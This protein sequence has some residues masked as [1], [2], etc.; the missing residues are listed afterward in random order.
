[1]NLAVW[2]AWGGMATGVGVYGWVWHRAGEQRR[3]WLEWG[4]ALGV[5]AVSLVSSATHEPWRDELHAWLQA[6]EMG[7]GALWEEMARE[8]HFLPWHL[9]LWPLAH[10]GVPVWTMG[11]VSWALNAAAVWW[12]ARRSPLTGWEKAAVG[13]SCVFLYVNPVISRCYALAP[14]ALSGMAAL[15]KKRDEWPMVFGLWVA[16]LANTHLCFEGV[17]VAAFG[18]FSW[19]NVFFRKDGKRG[20]GCGRQWA[21]LAIMAAGGVL[22][23]AQVLPSLWKSSVEFGKDLAVGRD[24]AWFF[25]GC[26]PAWGGV[27]M[28]A[29][30]AWLGVETWR[31]DKGA[32]WVYATGLAYMWCFSVF[33]YPG[34]VI[35]RALAW[36]PVAVWAAW[37]VAGKN[38][39]VGGRGRVLAVVAAG[40]AIARPDMTWQDARK[41]YDPLPAAC[42]WVADRYGRDAEVWINGDDVC[43]EGALVYLGNVS[44]WQTGKRAK[45][46]SWS[47]DRVCRIVYPFP[48]CVEAVFREHPEKENF[49]AVAALWKWGGVTPE[50]LKRPGIEVEQ[51]WNGA[52]WREGGIALAALRVRRR[53]VE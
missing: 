22:A 32:W 49:L 28:V 51:V 38:G 25:R 27:A 10:S 23:A 39:G 53:E 17:A 41:E 36:W 26:M 29:G 4:L 42:R 19:E 7:L 48:T 18:V 15:W 44:D 24:T 34:S 45:P 35:N 21:G 5:A 12:L 47:K 20:R 11:T 1:M 2:A 46:I 13:A 14:L 6:R 52:L 40:L 30:L 9:L 50:D 16:L 31:T 43:T 8:G 37:S 3:R 33:V